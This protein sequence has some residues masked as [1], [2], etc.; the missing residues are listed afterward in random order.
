MRVITRLSRL[1]RRLILAP[2]GYRPYFDATGL[3]KGYYK[4]FAKAEASIL[5]L[6]GE[7]ARV[8]FDEDDLLDSLKIAA[9]KKVD[10]RLISGPKPDR[11]SQK[12]WE[13]VQENSVP[14]GKLETRP[15]L[16]FSVIDNEYVRVEY[17]HQPG[18]FLR[19]GYFRRSADLAVVLRR[20]F[21]ELEGEA[22]PVDVAELLAEKPEGAAS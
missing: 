20:R 19:R 8:V 4:R 15:D 13:L 3:S 12:L 6:G 21:F 18:A 5:I 2:S 11:E 22:D 1:L 17:P 10:I 16:H 9:G 14:V 7:F